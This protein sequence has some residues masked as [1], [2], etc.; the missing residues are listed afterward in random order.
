[1]KLSTHRPSNAKL[2]RSI[3]W[4]ASRELWD[5]SAYRERVDINADGFVDSTR[6]LQ[7]ASL[8]P[9]L[10]VKASIERVSFEAS[11]SFPRIPYAIQMHL[12]DRSESQ[13]MIIRYDGVE[14]LSTTGLDGM[15]I[16]GVTLGCE[17]IQQGELIRHAIALIA[18]ESV[19]I[20]ARKLVFAVKPNI[21]APLSD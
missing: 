6:K 10:F 19:V 4:D 16:G 18:N 20:V 5:P 17:V 3:R 21:P 1:M 7:L 2:F 12:L 11:S 15:L 13:E 14:S 8:D 9:A